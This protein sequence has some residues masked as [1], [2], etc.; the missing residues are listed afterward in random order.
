[1]RKEPTWYVLGLNPIK[2]QVMVR[3]PGVRLYE[4]LLGITGYA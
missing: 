2:T 4:E 1:M 3:L